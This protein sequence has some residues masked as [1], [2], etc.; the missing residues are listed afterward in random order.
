M[1]KILIYFGGFLML[2]F[3][4]PAICTITASKETKQ[5]VASTEVSKENTEQQTPI[6]YEY[7]KYKTIKLLHPETSQI[8]ELNIDEYF[9]H[10][11]HKMQKASWLSLDVSVFPSCENQR[12]NAYFFINLPLFLYILY[13]FLMAKSAL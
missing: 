7:E 11:M 5:P 3:I 6:Q 1:K 13:N 10:I 9:V 2:F 8:E 12:R 4:I